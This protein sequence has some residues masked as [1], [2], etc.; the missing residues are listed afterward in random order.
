VYCDNQ[1][2]VNHTCQD[3]LSISDMIV[4]NQSFI[5][6]GAFPKPFDFADGILGLGYA[7]DKAILAMSP[8]ANMV[9]QG[10]LE[11]PKFALYLHKESASVN[12]GATDASHYHAPMVTLHLSG[13]T[14]W[15]V[16]L[17]ALTVGQETVN[18]VAMNAIFDSGTSVIAFPSDIADM[19]H[20]TIGARR[21]PGGLQHIIDCDKREALPDLTIALAGSNFTLSP[22]E[23]IKRS[24]NTCSSVIS[25]MDIQPPLGPAA[26]LGSPFLEKWYSVYDLGKRTVSLAL[27][28]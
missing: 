19:F 13:K 8:I 26:L 18:L 28:K 2:P 10:L 6:C 5:G 1:D 21:G 7:P 12:F 20:R 9:E 22:C 4:R 11:E 23:Y 16:A 25:G 15:A 14:G 27:A 24:G 17:S 3:T